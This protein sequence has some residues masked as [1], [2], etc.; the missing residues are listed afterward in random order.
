MP[1]SRTLASPGTTL[2]WWCWLKTVARLPGTVRGERRRSLRGSRVASSQVDRRVPVEHRWLGLDRRS[3]PYA[4]V[5]FAVLALWAWVM[6]WVAD[7][8]AWDDPIEAGEAIPGDRRG[9]DGGRARVGSRQRSADH[10]RHRAGARPRVR[11]G[12]AGQ[13]RGGV[14]HPARPVR[15]EP[16]AAAGPGRADH[17]RTRGDDGFAVSGE[18]ANRHDR[19]RAAGGR[20]GLHLRARRRDRHRRSWS[21]TPA[22][23]SSPSAPEPRWQHTRTRSTAM[24]DS[25]ATSDGTD[26]SGS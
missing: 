3:I 4:V 10:R 14:L 7:Q 2:V 6:P 19:F 9:D 17:R 21:T 12:R 26:G 23:R 5:A 8:V 13:G 24:I 1:R 25:L 15:R 20:P 11:S 18:V 16:C 22:S